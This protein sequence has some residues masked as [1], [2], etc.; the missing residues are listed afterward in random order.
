MIKTTSLNPYYDK[1]IRWQF[2]KLKEKDYVTLGEHPV[3]WCPK[4]N[5]PVSDHA[6]IK[7]EGETPQE[8]TLL[9]FKFGEEFILAA[10][11]RPETVY[12]QTNMWVDPDIQYVKAS[13][14]DEIW[15]MSKECADKL[16]EQKEDLEVVGEIWGGQMMGKTCMA[17]GINREILILPSDFCDP[18]KASYAC[19]Y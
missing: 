14:S 2:R 4:D 19:V 16:K 10:T 5:S 11:L 13:V 1:F 18:R 3:V 15:I 9:K 7:G 12:G 17:P 8:F 6:R